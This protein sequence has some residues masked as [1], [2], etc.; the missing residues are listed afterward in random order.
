MTILILFA[1]LSGVVTILSPCILPLLPVVLAGNVAG[2]RAR[3]YGVVTGFAVSFT[4]FT[5]A[6]SALVK[7]IGISADTLRIIAVVILFLFGVVLVVPALK[8]RVQVL[9]S[10]LTARSAAVPGAP[11]GGKRGAPA[12]RSGYV[13]GL[14]VGVSLG[15][16]WTPCVG[17]IMASV[18]SL[19]VSNTVNLGSILITVAY[20]LGTSIPMFLIMIGGRSLLR[21]VPWL[22]LRAAG[23]QR[24]FG[25]LMIVVAVVV[26]LGWDRTIETS[27]LTAA[28]GYGAGLTS[29]ENNGAV[30]HA[31]ADRHAAVGPQRP[32]LQ[33]NVYTM[34]SVRS[35]ALRDYGPAPPLV[36]GG[37]WF[38]SKPLTMRELRGKVVL[39]DF[40]TYSCINCIRTLPYVRSWYEKYKNDGFVVIGVHSPEFAFEH[41][42]AN[43]ARAVKELNVTWPVVQDNNFK[44]WNAYGNEYWPADYFIDAKGDVRYVHFGEGGY[45]KGEAVIRELLTEA[46]RPPA[47]AAS[48]VSS[49]LSVAGTPETYLGSNRAARFVGGPAAPSPTAA[50]SANGIVFSGPADPPSNHWDLA[51]TWKVHGQYITPIG[52]GTVRLSFDAKDVYLV[53]QVPGSS[54]A[55]GRDPSSMTDRSRLLI[56]VDGK[57]GTNTADVKDGVLVPTSSR[58]YHIA[59]LPTQGRHLLQIRARG[60]VRLFSFTFGG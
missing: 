7:A 48:A 12:E 19:A 54:K 18:I 53:L 28:P 49:G 16:V 24:A 20:S 55:A 29:I 30:M 36:A 38:N 3:P 1:F 34:A 59:A 9:L 10:R 51:G 27:L 56:T 21:K 8:D 5:L 47:V 26:A 50:A 39:V 2:G 14:L 58:M 35:P 60:N 42:P 57:P 22:T 31:L 4:A 13:S 37:K 45:A 44:E 41:N 15:V 23:I 46:G 6:L 25:A 17:P 32:T 33:A 11:L 40:W 43:V 52:T